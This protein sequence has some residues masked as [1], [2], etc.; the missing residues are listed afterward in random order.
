M[1]VYTPYKKSFLSQL[2]QQKKT[3]LSEKSKRKFNLN[4]ARSHC[5]DLAMPAKVSPHLLFK[6]NKLMNKQKIIKLSLTNERTWL[7]Q[8]ISNL[9]TA[10]NHVNYIL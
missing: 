7:H 6:Y 1:H 5:L 2:N 4:G 8:T 10:I 9:V 3:I